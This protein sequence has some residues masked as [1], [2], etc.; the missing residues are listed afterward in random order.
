MYAVKIPEMNFGIFLFIEE[1]VQRIYNYWGK[2]PSGIDILH[3]K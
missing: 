2:H 1:V 3:K